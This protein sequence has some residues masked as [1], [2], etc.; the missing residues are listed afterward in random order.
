MFGGINPNNSKV[1]MGGSTRHENDLWFRKFL[2]KGI[3]L[4]N[5][6]PQKA[7]APDGANWLSIIPGTDTAFMLGLAFE[8]ELS[9]IHI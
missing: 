9:L 2:N 4:I 6:S 1:S 8:L 5:I 7:D 3:N